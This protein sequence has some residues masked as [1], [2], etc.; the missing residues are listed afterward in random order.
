MAG[1]IVSVAA[2]EVPPPGTPFVGVVTVI[3]AVP[4]DAISS[5]NISVVSSDGP[6]Y[7]VVWGVPLKF[8]TELVTK[9][10]PFTD[11]TK[12]VPAAA[13]LDGWRDEIIGERANTGNSTEVEAPPPGR[14]LNT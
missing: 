5:L 4:G 6:W 13:T 14:G 3:L 2:L 8:T 12:E 1:V 10:E 7:E 11:K 9:F